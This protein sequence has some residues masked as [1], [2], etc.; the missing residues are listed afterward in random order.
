MENDLHNNEKSHV[1]LRLKGNHFRIFIGHS[2]KSE[3]CSNLHSYF[4]PD[5]IQQGI[6]MSKNHHCSHN[7]RSLDS[8][9]R[10]LCIHHNLYRENIYIIIF[11]RQT[12]LRFCSFVGFYF[13]FFLINCC[14]PYCTHTHTNRLYTGMYEPD[15]MEKI[16]CLLFASFLFSQFGRRKKNRSTISAGYSFFFPLFLVF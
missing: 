10:S 15:E 11:F 6:D 8:H 12:E 4:H 13:F 2:F 16:Q 9:R 5:D 3:R 1:G 7:W 14:L